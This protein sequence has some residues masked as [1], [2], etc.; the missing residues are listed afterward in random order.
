MEI[1][2]NK[3][4]K[5]IAVSIP[6]DSSNEDVLQ[7]KS[8][9]LDILKSCLSDKQVYFITLS[10]QKWSIGYEIG[11]HKSLNV[12]NKKFLVS[13]IAKVTPD[14]VDKIIVNNEEF[15]RSLLRFILLDKDAYINNPDIEKYVAIFEHPEVVMNKIVFAEDDGK[16]LHFYNY[17]ES[18]LMQL[19][20]NISHTQILKTE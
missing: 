11:E 18:E 19:I 14:I 16:A 4:S 13:L 17:E 6:F 1:K 9:V 10:P 12:L 8:F 3:L 20:G 15:D 2:I 5:G 7:W